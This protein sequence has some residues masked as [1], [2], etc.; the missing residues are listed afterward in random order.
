MWQKIIFEHFAGWN[1]CGNKFSGKP[2]YVCEK[3]TIMIDFDNKSPEPTT[4]VNHPSH[5][6]PEPAPESPTTRVTNHPS[7]QPPEPQT[8]WA[9]NHPSQHP[10]HQPPEPQTTRATN[11]PCHCSLYYGTIIKDTFSLLNRSEAIPCQ[12]LSQTL[13]A[14]Q[15]SSLVSVLRIKS[16]NIK[17]QEVVSTKLHTGNDRNQSKIC[18]IILMNISNG[19]RNLHTSPVKGSAYLYL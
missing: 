9:T 3:I 11:H 7:H 1:I 4:R 2:Y 15:I 13:P 14:W 10:S 5:Q 6:Q 19:V 18:G 17:S 16:E 8:I 12:L